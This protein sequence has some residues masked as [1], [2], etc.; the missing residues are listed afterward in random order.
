MRLVRAM[1]TLR[2]ALVSLVGAVLTIVVVVVGAGCRR[3]AENHRGPQRENRNNPSHC[4]LP[5]MDVRER[6][7]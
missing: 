6:R 2:H 7:S 5:S 4:G 3:R 1:V